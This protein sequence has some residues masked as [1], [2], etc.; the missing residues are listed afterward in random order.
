MPLS[1][2]VPA[3]TAAPHQCTFSNS[4]PSGGAIYQ[5]RFAGTTP[6]AVRYASG[7]IQRQDMGQAVVVG[8]APTAGVAELA[9]ADGVDHPQIITFLRDMDTYVRANSA[10]TDQLSAA[11]MSRIIRFVLLPFVTTNGVKS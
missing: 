5:I 1:I 2:R 6:Y 3:V 4:A 8:A 9:L 11:D 10:F 7:V